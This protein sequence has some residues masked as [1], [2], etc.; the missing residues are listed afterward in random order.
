[1]KVLLKI[2]LVLLMLAG[3]VYGWATYSMQQYLHT[4]LTLEK[5]M[6]LSVEAGDTLRSVTRKLRK[7]GVSTNTHWLLFR[8]RLDE[9]ASQI[10]AGDYT[11]EAGTTPAGLLEQLIKGDVDLE[12][13]TF[14]EG[15]TSAQFVAAVMDHPAIKNDLPIKL[16]ARANGEPWLD[17]ANQT[18]LASLVGLKTSHTEGRFAPDTLRFA[19]GTKASRLLQQSAAL[20]QQRLDRVWSDGQPPTPIQSPDELLTLA[21]IIEKESGVSDERAKIAGVFIRRLRKGMRLQ[22]DPTVIYGIGAAYDGDIRR[23]DLSN[24]TDYNTYTIDGL[25]PTPIAAPGLA[26][27]EAAMQPADG[28]EL[29]FVASGLGDGGHVF[30]DTLAEHQTAVAA[31]LKRLRQR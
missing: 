26:S 18:E 10:K 31:Y 9:T 7:S 5:P 15:W 4:P 14:L 22:T 8:A 30:S 21:S 25:P 17:D 16:G 3:L 11:V 19:A 2:V 20:M 13:V 1:M 23:K 27:I 24:K 12:S 6:A 28:T 29:Y